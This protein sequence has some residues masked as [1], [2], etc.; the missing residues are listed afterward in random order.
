MRYSV[1]LEPS[2]VSRARRARLDI[3]DASDTRA[4]VC[5][6]GVSRNSV[7]N[8]RREYMGVLVKVRGS[9]SVVLRDTPCRK[10]VDK[11]HD[12]PVFIHIPLPSSYSKKTPSAAGGV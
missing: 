5:L 8:N 9:E 6:S 4:D 2:P 11:S 1:L 10:H 12:T 3:A 7:R